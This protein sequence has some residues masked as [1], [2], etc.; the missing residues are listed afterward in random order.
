MAFCTLKY[1]TSV[2]L[3]K[4]YQILEMQRITVCC[5]YLNTNEAKH[6]TQKDSNVTTKLLLHQ[7]VIELFYLVFNSW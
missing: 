2:T 5:N 6:S 7:V 1:F 3:K 4:D